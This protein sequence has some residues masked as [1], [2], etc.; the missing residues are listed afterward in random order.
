VRHVLDEMTRRTL[1]KKTLALVHYQ[2]FSIWLE[3]RKSHERCTLTF[4]IVRALHYQ[5]AGFDTLRRQKDG[6]TL[7]R[8]LK[9][10]VENFTFSDLT[11]E[12]RKDKLSKKK[13]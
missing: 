13:R 8:S 11:L 10:F 9:M 5:G 4:P 1:C 3:S 12:R 2:I 7:G 6:E